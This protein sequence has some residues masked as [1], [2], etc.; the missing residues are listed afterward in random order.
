[1]A[2]QTNKISELKGQTHR[3]E[4]Q[5][6]QFLESWCSYS[7][8]CWGRWEKLQ[9]PPIQ[10]HPYHIHKFSAT[11]R[12]IDHSSIRKCPAFGAHLPPS[13]AQSK[14]L[15]IRKPKNELAA[16]Q[17]WHSSESSK[18]SNL[19]YKLWHPSH[20]LI[21]RIRITL[22]PSKQYLSQSDGSHFFAYN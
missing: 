17:I 20:Y 12:P 2:T 4:L 3:Q 14:P 5:I 9:S 10:V 11:A 7:S 13:Y 8:T 16:T 18:S 15:T 19:S 22:K 6:E 21:S 1:M